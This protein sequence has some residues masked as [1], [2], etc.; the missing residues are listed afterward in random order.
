[1]QLNSHNDWDKLIEVIVG[2]SLGTFPVITW[3]KPEKI[4]G[5][6]WDQALKVC[7]TAYPKWFYEEVEEDLDKLSA[8]LSNLG[9]KVFRPTPFDY[10]RRLTS[11]Y[12]AS[13]SNNSY[14]V[15]DLNLVVGNTLIESASPLHSRF[16]EAQTL[17]EIWYEYLKDGFNWL[18]APKPRLIGNQIV[19]HPG[20]PEF[21]SPA[22]EEAYKKLTNGRSE[23][24][25]TLKESEILFE[26][27]NTLRLGKDLLYLES[28]S[29]NKL[30]LNWLRQALGDSYRVHST[31]SIYRA[32]HIDSTILALKPG[33]ILV[34]SKRVNE[35]NLPK[36]FEK[37]DKIYFDDVAPTSEAELRFQKEYR[38]PACQELKN[39]GFDSNLGEMSSPWVG[40]NVLS[41][42]PNCVLVDARQ[43]SLMKILE[44]KKFTVVPVTMR[45]IY[46]QGGGIHCATL[47][48]VRES[49]LEDYFT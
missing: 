43:I 8:I 46:T 47:D 49:K 39:L 23:I 28:S 11:P 22:E 25:H 1:M 4:D 16:F 15:R 19:A 48:T 10:S 29:G 20:K 14:N 7:S 13:T 27:A 38:D 45:H 41:F 6:V 12:W 17:Y 9:S 30:G 40:M 2:S 36:I 3:A 44:E 32:S 18:C 35:S 33:L 31:S 42:S 34:N 21:I 24:L 37:W 5:A 26:A